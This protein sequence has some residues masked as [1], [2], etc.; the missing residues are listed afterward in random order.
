MIDWLW[1]RARTQIFSTAAPPAACAA[2]CEAID[3]IEREPERR[4]KLSSLSERLRAGLNVLGLE[5][6]EG[7]KG[8]IVPVILRNPRSAVAMARQ[9]EE[10]GFF[11]GAVRP[12]SVPLG[13]SRLRI[14]VTA[15]HDVQDVSDLIDAL[16][17]AAAA[18]IV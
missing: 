10:D 8:P 7:G 14:T 12:P 4:E 13:S 18:V 3:I 5:T 15:V 2:A 6:I 11:V 1:N 9:L 17:K 16:K